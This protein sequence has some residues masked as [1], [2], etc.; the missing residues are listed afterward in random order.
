MDRNHEAQVRLSLPDPFIL[1]YGVPPD[2][3]VNARVHGWL[4]QAAQDYELDYGLRPP[5]FRV[6]PT[7]TPPG[8]VDTRIPQALVFLGQGG[9]GVG[10]PR[11]KQYAYQYVWTPFGVPVQGSVV[12]HGKLEHNLIM[13]FTSPGAPDDVAVLRFRWRGVVAAAA[14]V[15]DGDGTVGPFTLDMSSVGAQLPKII[16]GTVVITAPKLV[17]PGNCVARDW[18]WPSAEMRK[19]TRRGRLIGDVDAQ[20]DSYIDYE[21]MTAVVKFSA[22]IVAAAGNIAADMEHTG[23]WLPIDI[24]VT[25]D[26]N[27][28]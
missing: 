8:A 18:P 16:P 5:T 26:L 7:G 28:I 3:E 2:A 25:F 12:P 11:E 21:A 24:R 19:E 10:G 23:T 9:P 4:N 17:G 15:G 22:A 27:T 6:P 14:V 20:F 13:P 1:F